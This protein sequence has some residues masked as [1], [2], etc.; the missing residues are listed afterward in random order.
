MPHA[1]APQTPRDRFDV[2]R[3]FNGISA[4]GRGEAAPGLVRTPLVKTFLLEHVSCH[5]GRQPKP[6]PALFAQVNAHLTSIDETFFSVTSHV[7]DRETG[8]SRLDVTGFIERYDE[9]FFAYYTCEE[10]DSARKRVSR[11]IQHPDLDATW[12]SSPLLQSLWDRDVSKR[13]DDRYAKL[14]FRHESIFDMPSDFASDASAEMSEEDDS[15][16][17]K[18]DGE[19]REDQIEPER[20]KARFDMGDRIGQ[21]SA[22]LKALQSNYAPLHVVYGLRLPSRFARGGHDLYQDGR[23]TNRADTFEDHRNTVRHLYRIYRS[24]LNFTEECAWQSL[25]APERRG[26]PKVGKKG[27]PLIIEFGEPISTR[28]FDRWVSMAFQKR[29][30]FKLWGNPIR[31]GPAKV[32]V[33]GADRHLW[34]PINL[35]ITSKGVVAILPRGTCG[36][37]FHRLVANIQHYVSPRI[38]AWIGSEPFES[39]VRRWPEDREKPE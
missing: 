34:Q 25:T 13:G 10:S 9:R 2:Y 7:T 24:V 16:P 14:T 21:I 22:S 6:A 18:Q 1:L 15:S 27:E 17:E 28:T 11:W 23:I 8:R 31:L 32:H 19:E 3:F 39:I 33:Y 20:R 29:N 4:E 12:F 30:R 5:G 37:T 26:G 35:E 38:Q 36:N